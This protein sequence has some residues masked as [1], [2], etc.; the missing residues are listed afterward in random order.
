MTSELEIL[1]KLLNDTQDAHDTLMGKL[2]PMLKQKEVLEEKLNH[3][4]KLLSLENG[5]HSIVPIDTES[6]DETVERQSKTTKIAGS[7]IILGVM[8][9]F[10]E[11]FSMHTAK[12][13][14]SEKF[15]GLEMSKNSWHNVVKK[16]M[17]SGQIIETRKGLG[18][19]PSTYRK[20]EKYTKRQK[21]FFY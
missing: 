1:T 10:I 21:G 4:K 18:R 2:S 16:K 12:E 5:S 11:D 17:K 9:D 3:Y 20:T 6:N 13:V 7:D 19:R 15:P 14:I 8:D